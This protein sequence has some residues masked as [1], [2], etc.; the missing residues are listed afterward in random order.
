MK[1][2]PLTQGYVAIIDDED[3]ENVSRLKW[4]ASP[5]YYTVYAVHRKARKSKPIY[6]HRFI[7]DC[8]PEKYVDHIDDNGLNCTRINL[9]ICEPAQNR[10]NARK[11]IRLCTSKFIGVSWS[12][13]KMKWRSR[14]RMNDHEFH[15]GH[16]DSE[17]EAARAYDKKAGELFG[18]FARFNFQT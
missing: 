1:E 9:R 11:I 5:R 18:E 17:E 14:I 16:F 7:M 13:Q 3:F 15:C 10:Q 8:P 4:H 2:I 6:L 12:K